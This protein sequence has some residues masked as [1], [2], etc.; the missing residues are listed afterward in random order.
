MS[1]AEILKRLEKKIDALGCFMFQF[2]SDVVIDDGL[3]DIDEIDEGLD[4][5]DPLDLI[6]LYEI[7]GEGDEADEPVIFEPPDLTE[8]PKHWVM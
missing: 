1:E 8:E 2:F 6:D 3:E 4:E 5:G 7:E